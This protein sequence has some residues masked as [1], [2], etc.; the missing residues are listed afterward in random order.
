MMLAT[1]LL[2]EYSVV[3]RHALHCSTRYSHTALPQCEVLIYLQ[4]FCLSLLFLD[5]QH[6]VAALDSCFDPCD[7]ARVPDEGPA[8]QV[9]TV[10]ASDD[11]LE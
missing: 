7:T 2:T 10:H 8:I 6:H 1:S 9:D 3:L 11:P 5:T 4:L